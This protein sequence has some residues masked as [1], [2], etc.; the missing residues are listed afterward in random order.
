MRTRTISIALSLLIGVAAGSAQGNPAA[1][2]AH[3]PLVGVWRADYDGLPG[4]VLV[5]TDE[6]GA[7]SG[8]VLFYFHT[9]VDV[10]HPWTSTPGIP[11]PV[12]LPSLDGNTLRF[13][14]SHRRAHPPRT[15]SDPPM[16]FHLRLLG[17][18]KAE[19]QNEREGSP[20]VMTRSDY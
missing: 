10:N 13:E 9:R 18:D 20:L 16:P 7:V 5:V 6:G 19:L 14:I 11:E 12:L 1:T 3:S 15:L 8:A 17:P 4:V 2:P